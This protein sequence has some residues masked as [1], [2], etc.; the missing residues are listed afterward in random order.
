VKTIANPDVRTAAAA[1]KLTEDTAGFAARFLSGRRDLYEYLP[2]F[3]LKILLQ[4][5]QQK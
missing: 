3:F 5:S 4:P 2:G 1:L